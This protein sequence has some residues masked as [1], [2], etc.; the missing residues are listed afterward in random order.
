MRRMAESARND[1][2]PMRAQDLVEVDHLAVDA[3]LAVGVDLDLVVARELQGLARLELDS[4]RLDLDRLA[5][6]E[7]EPRG[8]HLEHR[9]LLGQPDAEL[10]LPR[11]A[12]DFDELLTAG[13]LHAERAALAQVHLS[14]VGR[15]LGL[16]LQL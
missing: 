6:L 2:R 10:D 3:N 13:G 12:T 14:T 16:K 4:R 15:L 11:R 7:L 1:E 5:G 9:A 8:L